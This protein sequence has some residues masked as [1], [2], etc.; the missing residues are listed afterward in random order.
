MRAGCDTEVR[1]MAMEE[2]CCH[3]LVAGEGQFW[4]VVVL[5]EMG[6]QHGLEP[7]APMISKQLRSL[8]IGYVA[9]GTGNASF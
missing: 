2:V 6:Q 1:L 7:L 4:T 9:A 5:G 8:L 3:Q